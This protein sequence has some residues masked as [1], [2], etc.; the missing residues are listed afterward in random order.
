MHPDKMKDIEAHLAYS[1]KISELASSHRQEVTQLLDDMHQLQAEL[2][3]IS[4]AL[5]EAEQVIA[6][7]DRQ[8]ATLQAELDSLRS[9]R[10]ELFCRITKAA[11]DKGVAQDVE[12]ELR[13]AAMA[14]AS[15]LV[16]VIR[17]N[18]ALGYLDTRNLSSAELYS[19]LDEH[20]G[21][22][23]SQRNFTIARNRM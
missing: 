21:L 19:L 11:F 14:S 13:S 23:Y 8:L 7:K 15:K 20:F 5:R 12:D 16:A 6:D 2:R 4:D 1:Q 3:T 17:T 18:E 9:K 22:G 10:T